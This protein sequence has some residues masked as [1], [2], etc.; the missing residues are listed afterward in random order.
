MRSNLYIKCKLNFKNWPGNFLKYRNSRS[1][2]IGGC[3]YLLDRL[4][5]FLLLSVT[6]SPVIENTK[7]FEKVKN[8]GI[9][10]EKWK[11][12]FSMTMK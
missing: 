9:E 8:D 1:K 12:Y 10:S 5:L 11:E 2:I 4:I 7:L 6:V 3:F